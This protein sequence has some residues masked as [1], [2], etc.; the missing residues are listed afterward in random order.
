MSDKIDEAS[1]DGRE[2]FNKAANQQPEKQGIDSE[3][4]K[5]IGTQPPAPA[6]SKAARTEQARQTH[7][8]AMRQDSERAENA[9]I[10]KVK[11][12]NDKING[13]KENQKEQQLQNKKDKGEDDLSK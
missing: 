12:Y 5:N 1:K 9:R 7:Q 3:Q 2:Q 6:P 13:R 4:V 10:E 11:A 8:E